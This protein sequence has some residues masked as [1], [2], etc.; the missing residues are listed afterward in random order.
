[1][2]FLAPHLRLPQDAGRRV[3]FYTL[4]HVLGLDLQFHLDRKTGE[5][6]RAV[7]GGGGGGPGGG[8]A[9]PT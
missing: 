9:C 5:A 1:M 6:G 8:A 2:T 3:S 4:S 7:W